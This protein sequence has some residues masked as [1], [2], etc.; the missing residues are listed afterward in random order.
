MAPHRW[1]LP[2]HQLAKLFGEPDEN[3]SGSADVVE[4]IGVFVLDHFVADELRATLAQPGESLVNVV[5][6]NMTRR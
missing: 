2:R 6:L 1:Q 5:D 4:P 3:A